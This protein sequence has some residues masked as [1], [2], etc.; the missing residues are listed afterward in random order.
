LVE[1]KDLHERRDL[2]QED[3]QPGRQ[4]CDILECGLTGKCKNCISISG[5]ERTG[6]FG[7]RRWKRLPKRTIQ[8]ED[9]LSSRTG[10]RRATGSG[11]DHNK[12]L[13]QIEFGRRIMANDVIGY[14]TESRV[15]F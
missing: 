15:W 11:N 2:L 10:V 3:T 8:R 1:W 4:Q 6:Y 12:S 9:L 13:V 7:M 5:D 14:F